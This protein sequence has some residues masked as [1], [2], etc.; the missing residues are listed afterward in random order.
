MKRNLLITGGAGFIGSNL[1]FNW[2][3][4]NPDDK[5]IV[6]DALTYAGNISNIKDLIENKDIIFEQVNL[7]DRVRLDSVISKYNIT[8]VIHMAAESHV[9]RSILN[10]KMFIE[11][12]VVGTFNLLES[13]RLHWQKSDYNANFKFLHVSTDEVFGALSDNEE[14]FCETTNYKPSSPYSASKASSDHLAWSWHK[15]YNLPILI[16]NCSNN[17]GP[18]QFPEKLIPLTIQNILLGK[19]IPIYG[20]GSN[21]RDWLHVDDHCRALD[22]ILSKAKPGSRYCIGGNN[23]IRNLDLVI[24]ICEL[25]DQ[26]SYQLPIT[27]SKD[28]LNFVTDRVGHDYRYAI[29]SEC[30]NNQL[31]WNPEISLKDGLKKTIKWYINNQHWLQDIS[32][33]NKFTSS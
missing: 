6:L 22:L 27:P 4:K 9:D 23:E 26:S 14:S 25:M 7:L 12:N 17:Y 20:K 28:L 30:I 16:S 8:H 21:I 11:T 29:N 31:G 2:I 19:S 3:K 32:M 15:T 1:V 10:P 5:I 24:L 13:F 33:K 18:F